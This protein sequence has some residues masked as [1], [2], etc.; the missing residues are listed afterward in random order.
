MPR[1][2]AGKQNVVCF[3][4]S[5][6]LH[7]PPVRL[8]STLVSGA[9]YLPYLKQVKQG[10]LPLH[11]GYSQTEKDQLTFRLSHQHPNAKAHT[12]D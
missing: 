6:F 1:I 2:A 11:R 12:R 7:L 10:C 4:I 9:L 8:C 3:H 5:Y